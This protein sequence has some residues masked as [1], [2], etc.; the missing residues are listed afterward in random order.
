MLTVRSLCLG[1]AVLL[2]ACASDGLERLEVPKE[3]G[4]LGYDLQAGAT[5]DGHLKIG[6]TREIT[7]LKEHLKQSV[8][9]DAKLLVLGR[10]AEHDGTV[11]AARFSAIDLDWGVA[12]ELA[13]SRDEFI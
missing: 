13:L 5:Y 1:V 2:A 11:V 12:P 6:T 8:E 9:F 4:R 7:G 3:G 10:D